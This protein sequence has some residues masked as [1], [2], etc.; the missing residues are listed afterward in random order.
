MKNKRI[1]IIGGGIGGLMTAIALNK[2]GIS[3]T[4]YEKTSS[5]NP[6]GAG[7]SLWA[8]A[9]K[10][11]DEH[12]L[13][14]KLLPYSNPLNEMHTITSSGNPL[15]VV[16]LK[17]LEERF[18]FPS[19]IILR[20][21][22][23]QVLLDM[24]PALQV[25]FDKQ[26]TAIEEGDDITTVHFSD[27]TSA[28]A[29]AV[30]FADGIHSMARKTVFDLPPLQ[31]TN[32]VSWRGVAEFDSPVIKDTNC[33]ELFG[34]GKRIGI[35]PLRGNNIYWYA[36]VNMSESESMQQALTKESILSHFEG[37]ADP[38]HKLI[39]HTAESRLILTNI[40]YTPSIKKL[41]K[42][43]IALLGDAAHP[44]TP[45]LGQGACQAIEDACVMA[46]CIAD[47][48]SITDAFKAYENARLKRVRTIADRSYRMGQMRQMGNPFT[49]AMR[50]ILM[51]VI[52]ESAALK[53][54]AGNIR[55]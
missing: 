31:Y 21:D 33:Y 44:M 32:R 26:Y 28:T 37:W 4:V 11:L 8:N 46:G 40:N 39:N 15:S 55:H 25:Q 53:L 41:V 10:L 48:P 45:D 23:Q 16:H 49:S 7:L 47:H 43:N 2:K 5:H 24:V 30:I 27:G 29:D 22:L 9:T 42:G 50:N 12:G 54:L 13:L 3:A 38:V 36:S 35:F 19:L 14:S 20:S 52:P 6:N 34:R 51:K 1:I 17:K 18:H